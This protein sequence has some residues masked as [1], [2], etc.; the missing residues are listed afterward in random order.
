MPTIVPVRSESRI[1]PP[2]P[3]R[4]RRAPWPPAWPARRA[5]AALLVR[6]LAGGPALLV[7]GRAALAHHGYLG[8]HDFSR[9]LYLAGRVTRAY[10]GEPHGRIGLTVARDL[11]LPRDLDSLRAIED[12][13]R[14]PTLSMLVRAPQRGDVTLVLD[15]ATTRTLMDQP[16]RLQVGDAIEAIVYQRTSGDEY[17]DE[18]RVALLVLV[19]G[20]SLA[21]S[22]PGVAMHPS[23]RR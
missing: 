1:R 22:T 5:A 4:P 13:E 21:A 16:E 9:P 7:A 12:A 2:R 18:L 19:D 15:G 10:I 23:A 11:H 20:R 17:R 6:L 8:K 14:R 3:P